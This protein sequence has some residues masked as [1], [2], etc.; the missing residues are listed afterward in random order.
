MR[1]EAFRSS[2]HDL[3]ALAFITIIHSVLRERR[4]GLAAW[5]DERAGRLPGSGL[6]GCIALAIVQ[7]LSYVSL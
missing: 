4:L 5:H 6:G 3:A 2:C 1:A 7:V